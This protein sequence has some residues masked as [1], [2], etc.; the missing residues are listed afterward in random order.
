MAK[1]P[2][3]Q[4]ANRGERDIE[5]R[6]L[7]QLLAM[8]GDNAAQKTGPA[9]FRMTLYTG[10][11]VQ[12]YN[13]RT[14]QVVSV[15]LDVAGFKP[16]RT[17]DLPAMVDHYER[18]GTIDA[19]TTD[20][21]ASTITGTGRFLAND[22]ELFPGAAR[23][24]S[25][26]AQS[27]ALQCSGRWVPMKMQ[28]LAAGAKDTVNGKAVVGPMEIWREFSIREGSFCDLG[29]D[30]MT[31]A[32]LAARAEP[33]Q[34]LS[35]RNEPEEVNM[36]SIALLAALKPIFG[37]D[38]AIELLASKPESEDLSAFASE[39]A[40]HATSLTTRVN[41]LEASVKTKDGEIATLKTELAASK[42][43]PPVKTL[44]GDP[45]TPPAGAPAAGSDADLKAK[46]EGSAD[47]KAEFGDFERFLAYS[48]KHPGKI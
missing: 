31:H 23:A 33:L 47:L 32:E 44:T 7:V 16:A 3:K 45:A 20:L 1:K 42:S 35:E 6:G 15:I 18:A 30:E 24:Q 13:W 22:A 19:I 2:T 38:R 17:S 48:K 26:L 14:D 41:E 4:N 28:E 11:T 25:I 43:A 46:Y 21:T 37:A 10:E 36:K 39:I 40:G 29:R 34:T 9:K 27:H 5:S 8:E 12:R